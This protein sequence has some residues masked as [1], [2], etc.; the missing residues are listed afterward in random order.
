RSNSAAAPRAGSGSAGPAV[1]CFRGLTGG[2]TDRLRERRK[3]EEGGGRREAGNA[4]GRNRVVRTFLQRFTV[5]ATATLAISSRTLAQSSHNHSDSAAT[6]SA[7]SHDMAGMDMGAA[8]ADWKMA[9][10]AKH[11]TYSSP[12]ALTAADS[13]R[14]AYVINDLRQA[15]AKY[16]DVKVAEADGYKMFAPQIK[17]QPQ[18]HFTKRWNAFRNQWGFDPARPTSLLYKRDSQG[19]F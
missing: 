7:S 6:A 1:G 9:A 15:I 13:I 3:R 14:S 16:Q 17:N 19:Q 12:R 5:V 18:Y 8:S 11:M 2:G 10:M 4:N